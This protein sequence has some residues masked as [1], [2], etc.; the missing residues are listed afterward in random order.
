E[1]LPET[2]ARHFQEFVRA[3]HQELQARGL[4]LE[5]VLEPERGP[6]PEVR[7][8]SVTV[9]AYDLFGTHS[10]PG[11]RSTPAYV[12]Q[13]G[14]RAAIDAD[15][16]GTLALAVR[17]FAWKPDGEVSSLDWSVAQQ[18]ADRAPHTSRGTV[19]RVP[20]ARLDDGTELW[21]EDPESLLSKWQ[22]AWGT[23]FRQLALWRLGGNDERLFNLLSDVRQGSASR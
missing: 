19:D 18:L 5:A 9:M 17:G 13:L 16:A 3:L 4:G 12:S 7:T 21:F 1:G 22:A 14:S 2:D 6:L 23:G 20:S 8:T 15:S 10:G 11:P